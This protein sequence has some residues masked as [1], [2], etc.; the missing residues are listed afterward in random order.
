MSIKILK[1]G[2]KE[3]TAHCKWCGCEFAYEISDLKLS[4]TGDKLDCPCCGKT[5]YHTMQPQE[6]GVLNPQPSIPFTT[7]SDPCEGCVWKDFSNKNWNYVG[8]TP[9]T[10][11]HKRQVTNAAPTG[12]TLAGADRIPC[13]CDATSSCSKC[14]GA[15]NVGI[16]TTNSVDVSKFKEKIV[17]LDLT[18]LCKGD[19]WRT[20]EDCCINCVE[21]INASKQNG[22]VTNA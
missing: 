8:D 17:D 19:V 9:C 15:A 14:S 7:Y 2:Q 11:C 13:N 22:G 21:E 6:P 1:E 3:F 20:I 10:W 18:C 4:A 5:Y 16:S 12:I